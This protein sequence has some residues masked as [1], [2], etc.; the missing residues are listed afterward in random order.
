MFG[1]KSKLR[2]RYGH[3]KKFTGVRV[4]RQDGKLYYVKGNGEV[5]EADRKNK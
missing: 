1:R 5:W 2:K 4:K 3:S